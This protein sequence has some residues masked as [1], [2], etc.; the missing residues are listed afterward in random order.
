MSPYSPIEGYKFIYKAKSNIEEI[1]KFLIS[2]IEEFALRNNILSCNFLYV[3]E[4]WGKY[5]K[6]LG[7]SEWINKRSQWENNGEKTF[8]D[9]LSRFNSNQRKNIKKERKS[10]LNREIKILTYSE[11]NIDLKIMKYMHNFYEQHCL[12][13]GVWGSKYLTSHFFENIA[14]NNQNLLIFSASVRSSENPIAMSMCIRNKD[15]LWGRYWGSNEEIKNL[16]FELCYY[17]PIEWSIKNN[18]KRFDPGAGGEHKRR[19]GFYAKSTLSFHKWFNRRME[20]I[21]KDWLK[22]ANLQKKDEIEIENDSIPFNK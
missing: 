11:K 5:L 3:N 18:I 12:K 7:Y 2:Q 9:F 15:S 1:T 22:Q 6:L 16:H 21:I 20:N 4:E 17:Q 13:W 10:L 19:R 8:E 14:Q